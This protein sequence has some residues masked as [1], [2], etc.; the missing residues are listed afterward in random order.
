[1]LNKATCFDISGHHQANTRN[2]RHKR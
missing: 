2:I 1:V